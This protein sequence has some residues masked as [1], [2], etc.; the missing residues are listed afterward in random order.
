MPTVVRP[1]LASLSARP[2]EGDKWLH[3]I[4]IDGYRTVARID[5]GNVRLLTR[6]GYDWTGYYGRL[7]RICRDMPCRQAI[8]DGE[9]AVQDAAGVSDFSALEQALSERRTEKL[10]YFA[11]DL[12]FLDGYDL[13]QTPLLDRKQALSAILDGSDEGSALQVS[14]YI[15]GNGRAVFEQACRMSLEGIVCKRLDA[16]YQSGRSRS[17]IKVKSHQEGE[18]VVVGYTISGATGGLA[19]VHVAE[20]RGEQLV[21]V[22]KVGTGFTVREAEVLASALQTIRRDEPCLTVPKDVRR[23]PVTWVMPRVVANVRYCN[24]T[25]DGLLRH[26]VF[27]GLAFEPACKRLHATVSAD[28][29][30]PH[31]CGSSHESGEVS[32]PA[33]PSQ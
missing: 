22:G 6:N 26:P 20:F 9:V 14:D 28:D 24:R 4:K 5:N 19:A 10:I 15:I 30:A 13:T 21:Y 32:T 3:E 33:R 2:P 1:Q 8:I 27:T 7:A 16:A 12:L 29:Q 31:V 11:F 23:G 25:A 17:W 18:F